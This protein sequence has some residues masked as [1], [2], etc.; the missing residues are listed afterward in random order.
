MEQDE[1][2]YQY[3]MGPEV[4]R[5]EAHSDDEAKKYRE[6]AMIHFQEKLG[7]LFQIDAIRGPERVLPT[8]AF[9]AEV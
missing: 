2:V 1:V 4:F 9:R 5:F 3:L 6:Y 7:G 8:P